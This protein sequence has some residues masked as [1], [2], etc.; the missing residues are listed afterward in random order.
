MWILTVTVYLGNEFHTLAFTLPGTFHNAVSIRT[1]IWR[2]LVLINT[3]TMGLDLSPGY[4]TKK[5][6]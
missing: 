6:L 5:L 4:V 1:L 3:L 2:P